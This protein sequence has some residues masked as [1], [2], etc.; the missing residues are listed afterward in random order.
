MDIESP[1][2]SMMV[3]IGGIFTVTAIILYIF[4]PKKINSLYGYRTASSMTSQER[5]QFA[6]RFSAVAML[7]SGLG[8]IV[9]SGLGLYFSI[10]PQT[11]AIFAGVFVAIAVLILFLRTEIALKR[12]R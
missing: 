2:F 9:L 5:W 3:L 12:F 11:D 8:L 10:S 7:Q 1:F 6:Q 4:P